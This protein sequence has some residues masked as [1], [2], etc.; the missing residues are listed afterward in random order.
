MV[1]IRDIVNQGRAEHVV[2]ANEGTVPQELT[3][4]LLRSATGGQT[5]S[6]PAGF[7]L[8]AGATVNVHSGSGDPAALNHPPSD[9]FATRSNVWRNEG[10]IGQLIDPTGRAVSERRYGAP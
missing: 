2:V 6:F 1:V 5:Y 8:A 9:L 7:V 3:G 4:W 10:D